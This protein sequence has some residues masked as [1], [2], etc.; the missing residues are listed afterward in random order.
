MPLQLSLK[1][2][3]DGDAQWTACLLGHRLFNGG[4]GGWQCWAPFSS[5]TF[6]RWFNQCGD[7]HVHA[8]NLLLQVL[9][10]HS[11]LLCQS[12]SSP[13]CMTPLRVSQGQDQRHNGSP[14]N[15]WLCTPGCVCK[16]KA[17]EEISSPTREDGFLQKEEDLWARSISVNCNA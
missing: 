4:R 15:Q 7:F 5:I 13:G 11:Q 16:S 17:L 1:M 14:I 3:S 8:R 9:G 6:S 2:M 12:M 10:G